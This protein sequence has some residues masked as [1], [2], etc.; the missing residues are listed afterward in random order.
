MGLPLEQMKQ[1][2][3]V[4]F[5]CMKMYFSQRKKNHSEKAVMTSSLLYQASN[6]KILWMEMYI[7][8][9]LVITIS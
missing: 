6:I 7:T 5:K 1:L 9:Y 3:L 2:V 4:R 8:T